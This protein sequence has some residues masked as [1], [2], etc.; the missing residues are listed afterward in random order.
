MATNVEA[1]EMK[2]DY[3]S[4]TRQRVMGILF[5][6]LAAVIWFY[7]GSTTEADALTTFRLSPGGVEMPLP[8][9][10]FRTGAALNVMA[11]LSAAL[12]A[13]QL[14]RG[15]GQR[16]NLVLGL[17]A[18]LFMFGFL[19]WAASGGSLNM[20]GLLR[21]T[22][23]RAVPITLGA[24][25]GVL[26]ERSGVVNIAIE[27]MMLSGAMVGLPSSSTVMRSLR[28][29]RICLTACCRVGFGVT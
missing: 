11:A 4:N 14:V 3:Q 13:Y 22:L 28:S 20:A 17:V 27:G 8:N 1:I 15:F 16:T 19:S 18:G 10:E 26:C 6:L 12:G 21:E 24:L 7:F 23:V 29:R 25:S 5:L 2:R 9:W